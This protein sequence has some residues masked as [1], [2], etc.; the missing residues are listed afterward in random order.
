MTIPAEIHR[1]VIENHRWTNL[2]PDREVIDPDR[3]I[4]L[5]NMICEENDSQLH[6]VHENDQR[7]WITMRDHTNERLD[8]ADSDQDIVNALSMIVNMIASDPKKQDYQERPAYV[9]EG[10]AH[11]SGELL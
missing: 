6:L 11:V 3:L 5:W 7:Q 4:T 2:T 10:V 9:Y 1:Q 8:Q